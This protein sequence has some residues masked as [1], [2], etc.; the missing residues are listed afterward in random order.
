LVIRA[1]PTIK[2]A[3]ESALI[4]ATDAKVLKYF[5]V[6]QDDALVNHWH[7]TPCSSP[8]DPDYRDMEHRAPT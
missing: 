5:S 6:G 2:A 8:V 4:F 1:K 7:F 3:D